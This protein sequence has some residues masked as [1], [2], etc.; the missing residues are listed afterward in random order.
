LEKIKAAHDA[1]L[2]AQ[3]QCDKLQCELRGRE[4][5]ARI[6]EEKV[7]A[8]QERL[9]LAEKQLA[10]SVNQVSSLFVFFC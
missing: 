3:Q 7:L 9:E 4:T 10:Q 6:N 8:V 1:Q 2:A 5:A